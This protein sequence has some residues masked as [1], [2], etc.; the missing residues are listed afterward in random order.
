MSN[1]KKKRIVFGGIVIG[2]LAIIVLLALAGA[3]LV[4]AEEPVGSDLVT[5]ETDE[6]IEWLILDQD[7]AIAGDEQVNPE[8]RAFRSRSMGRRAKEIMDEALADALG[9]TVEELQAARQEARIVALDQAVTEGLMARN[10]A[11]LLKAR[12]ALA[13]TIDKDEVLADILGISVEELKA[14]RD[15]GKT[16]PDLAAELNLERSDLAR[17][18]PE[19]RKRL[20]E[21]AVVDGIITEEQAELLQDYRPPALSHFRYRWFP[22]QG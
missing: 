11:E 8:T 2:C 20:L 16:L 9:I 15:E 22:G 4:V 1:S 13:R 17:R 5:P 21:Q 3:A 12:I 19:V 6:W 10:R 18:W 14:A 7:T